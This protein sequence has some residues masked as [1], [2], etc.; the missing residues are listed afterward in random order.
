MRVRKNDT[1]HLLREAGERRGDLAFGIVC[2]YAF[3]RS[4]RLR[5]GNG[6]GHHG[7]EDAVR[8]PVLA[9]DGAF[10]V[11]GEVVA[12]VVER[13]EDALHGETGVYL[14]PDPRHGLQEAGHAGCREVFG[15]N[16]DEDA[17]RGGQCIDGDYSQGGCAVDNDVAV[18]RLDG[19]EPGAH[20]PLAGH[21][22]EH[23]HFYGGELDVG[24]HG[25]DALA[26]AEH[27]RRGVVVRALYRG[28]KVGGEGR[29]KR[30]RVP[31]IRGTSSGLPGDR[32]RREAP[33]S[34]S[35]RARLPDSAPWRSWPSLPSG[36]RRLSSCMSSCFLPSA[37]LPRL[38]RSG[39]FGIA[40]G[41]G[42]L[43]PCGLQPTT[44]AFAYRIRERSFPCGIRGWKARDLDW[45][46][47]CF[48]RFANPSHRKCMNR[49]NPMTWDYLESGFAR[50]VS[51]TCQPKHWEARALPLGDTRIRFRIIP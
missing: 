22:H 48:S 29:L 21:R 14:P 10:H 16:R 6:A 26:V 44:H 50:E 12:G 27:P 19:R 23:H 32:R 49:K 31:S 36:W 40:V 28:G 7:L 13:D 17:V 25:V 1:G 37:A 38:G 4:G 24:G 11:P 9:S 46:F 30:V 33:G 35:W 8:L 39:G 15:G 51:G 42:A 41:S 43:S 47:Q 18:V 3:T 20:H 2:E 5:G 45:N 34:P